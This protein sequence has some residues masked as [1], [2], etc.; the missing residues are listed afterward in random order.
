M[1]TKN[2]T[3]FQLENDNEKEE[4]IIEMMMYVINTYSSPSRLFKSGGGEILSQEGTTQGDPLI[5]P[6]Y[7]VNTSIII[8]AMRNA[9]PETDV[10]R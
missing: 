8:E 9:I 3:I 10:A 5:M 6:W 4:M 2:S 7:S 1:R